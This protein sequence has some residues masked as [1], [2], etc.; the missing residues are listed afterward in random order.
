MS[1]NKR[2]FVRE[3]Q[4][5]R[6]TRSLK[7]SFI[8]HLHYT[9]GKDE[10]AATTR[11]FYLALS[12]SIRDHL[13]DR[14]IYSQRVFKEKDHKRVYYLSLEF[15]IG[16]S[17]GNNLL[18]LDMLDIAKKALQELDLNLDDLREAEWDAGLGNG[19]LGRLAACYMDSLATQ[20]MPAVGYG[21]R[22][23][24][25]IFY[26]RI[27][28]GYQ[29]ET[30][31]SWLRYGNPWEIARPQYLYPVKFGGHVHE[32]MD[33]AGHLKHEWKHSEEIMAMAY[34]TPIPGFDNDCI[35]TMRLWSAKSSREF[36]LEYFNHGDYIQAVED[37]NN[38]ENISRVLYP[39]D[40]VEEGKTLRLKQEYFLV[41]AT[42]QDIIRR[43]KSQNEGFEQFAEKA[44][45]QLNDTHPA[46]A[47]PELMRLL[48][49]E[50]DL[51]WE[52]AWSITQN[53]LAYTNHT[54]LPEA[55][56]K[57]PL[58][59]MNK[60]LPRHMQIIFEINRCFLKKA[61]PLLNNDES[62]I[63]NVSII[64][65]GEGKQVRMANLA[66]VGGHAINGVSALHT[67]ILKDNL[68]SDFY[69]IYPERFNNKTNGITPRRW[70]A[71]CN[72]PL[73]AL[74][75][76][77]IGRRWVSNLEELEKLAP[78]AEDQSFLQE[79]MQVKR[80]N[81]ER[82]AKVIQAEHNIDVNLD[83]M[84]D[85]QIKRIHEYKRQV[86]CLFHAI[87]LYNQIKDNPN[88]NFP[89][90]TILIGGK[91]APGYHLA[92]LIIKLINSVADVIN[93]DP[94]TK[95]RLRLHF[96]SNYR[97]S[98][99]E[100]IIPATDLSEQISLAGMEASGTGNMKFALNGSLTIGTLD[101]ANVEML[102]HIGKE[103]IFI[104]GMTKEEMLR[105]RAEGYNPR[106]YYNQNEDIQRILTMVS[107][108][109]FGKEPP[110]LFKPLVDSL[111][112]QG[113]Y[114]MLL[115]DFQSYID[116]Q[117]EVDAAFQDPMRWAK[118]SVL[119]VA[120]MGFFSSDRSIAE[121][122]KDIWGVQPEKSL[123]PPE[124]R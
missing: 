26:Q 115:K 103:N 116:C 106:D 8:N 123:L 112:D 56:E 42:L 93:N 7:K 53:S 79:W 47:V 105:T 44:A 90:R 66:I 34:D 31:D 35:N 3:D 57:W 21:I 27:R 58:D 28:D 32:Y 75:T 71:K 4:L 118:M 37:K 62:R 2:V 68:F 14:W 18:C 78:L 101:G 11:D 65:E 95:G 97:V 104:F 64:E 5:E 46:L 17:L 1:D 89:P 16:R 63:R 52:L 120:N 117:R 88:C 86:L 54:I 96:M 13:M 39:N 38:S 72:D 22:Y 36:N 48:M 84:F 73:S 19:G 122:A 6:S 113:D 41:S 111:L 49:D 83:S 109:T 33:E 87:W 60:L 43:Y 51:S 10:S 23:E 50:E 81:K 85:S 110:E 107:D 98:L 76:R 119:N 108:G 92:K 99:A 67:E 55:L 59:L 25:G 40:N 124:R 69:T 82:L 61:S 24:Y 12:Y 74:I 77:C 29:V 102:E 80:A 94:V 114:F 70:L 91:A 45:I 15:L 100:K 30:P 9:I 121:Y 20:A